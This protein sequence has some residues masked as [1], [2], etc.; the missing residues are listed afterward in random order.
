MTD[1]GGYSDR[2]C[3]LASMSTV[4]W[5]P[6]FST[7]VN[8]AHQRKNPREARPNRDFARVFC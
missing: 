1:D 4:P 2:V 8:T 7:A 5:P 3:P 6:S